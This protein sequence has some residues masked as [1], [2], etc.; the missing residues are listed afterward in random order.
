MVRLCHLPCLLQA[1]LSRGYV[2]N[3]ER[4]IPDLVSIS[5]GVGSRKHNGPSSAQPAESSDEEEAEEEHGV[6]IYVVRDAEL[7]SNQSP[8]DDSCGMSAAAR[9]SG[10]L[11]AED[12]E[13]GD[14]CKGEGAEGSEEQ[15]E[16]HVI[17]EMLVEVEDV[18][19]DNSGDVNLFSVIL[20][21]L[22]D[23]DE[24]EQNSEDHLKWTDLQPLLLH[25]VTA[26]RTPEGFQPVPDQKQEEEE[27]EEEEFSGYLGHA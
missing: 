21:A 26:E 8:R 2:I 1:S 24:E 7:S 9:Y 25:D 4:T 6:N 12:Q 22:A 13:C 14:E 3:P 11:A 10:S 5:P 20:G 17:E 18:V 23:C 15:V 16:E 27:E 19:F